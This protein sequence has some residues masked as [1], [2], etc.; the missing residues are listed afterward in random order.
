MDDVSCL[1]PANFPPTL[2]MLVRKPFSCRS[3][4]KPDSVVVVIHLCPQVLQE[5]NENPWSWSDQNGTTD[6]VV[7]ICHIRGVV[8]NANYLE[9][10]CGMLSVKI[11]AC[12]QEL[13][14]SQSTDLEGETLIV[15]LDTSRLVT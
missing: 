14:L 6:A 5:D 11:L 7:A 4:I 8:S 13:W 9:C 1:I 12:F 10:D 15:C 2:S 3:L